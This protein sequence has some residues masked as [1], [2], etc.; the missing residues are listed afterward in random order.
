MIGD[1]DVAV[2][3]GVDGAEVEDVVGLGVLRVGVDVDVEPRGAAADLHFLLA[4]RSG[5]CP[6]GR[7][8][9]VH[10]EAQVEVGRRRIGCGEDVT[11][12]DRVDP[13]V[14]RK[15]VWLVEVHG[16]R[17]QRRTAVDAR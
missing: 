10:V 17:C 5:P 3:T 4:E 1:V 12:A 11:A 16:R 13:I 14:E 9:G 6:P 7:S 8:V 2:E 15:H